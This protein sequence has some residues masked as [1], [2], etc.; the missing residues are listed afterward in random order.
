MADTDPPASQSLAIALMGPFYIGWSVNQIL[1]GV[2]ITLFTSY[3]GS[4]LYKRDARYV[5]VSIWL[6]VLI[7]TVNAAI[8]MEETFHFGVTQDRDAETFFRGTFAASFQPLLTGLTA[9]LVQSLL[10]IRASKLFPD[11][12]ARTA[13]LIVMGLAICLA[14]SGSCMVASLAWAFF[15]GKTLPMNYDVGNGIWMWTSASVDVFISMALWY[16][17]K[18]HI[19]GFNTNT[20][21]V[22]RSIIRVS[23]RTAL[24]TSILSVVGAAL[25]ISFPAT[26]LSTID[27]STAFWLP[28][29]PLHA[30]SFF[31]TLSSRSSIQL[32]ASRF[33]G[34]SA[35]GPSPSMPLDGTMGVVVNQVEL[36]KIEES[37]Q[38]GEYKFPRTGRSQTYGYV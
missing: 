30:L 27:I 11:G 15:L 18:K 4:D 2:L 22:L 38:D 28:L 21:S 9:F 20:D 24:Y 14:F 8:S 13:F 12:H 5:K 10:T 36:T 6:I 37:H 7:C 25:S 17:L 33:Q 16:T 1:W 31:T 3:L 23:L 32:A 19:V 29:S 34:N 26:N 35:G